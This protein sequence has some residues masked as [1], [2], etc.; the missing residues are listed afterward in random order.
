MRRHEPWQSS[1]HV[2]FILL[3]TKPVQE[4]DGHLIRDQ[5][6]FGLVYA[7]PIIAWRIR[8]QCDEVPQKKSAAP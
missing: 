7:L 5:V 3:Q 1:C 2:G 8:L 6:R 4:S